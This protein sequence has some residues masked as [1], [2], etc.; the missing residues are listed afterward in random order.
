LKDY[1]KILK[2]SQGATDSEIKKSYRK[3][4]LEF[5]PDKN[6]SKEAEEFF[7]EISEAYTVLSD[8]TKRKEYDL[9]R[10]PGGRSGTFGFED[11]VNNFSKDFETQE[12]FGRGS[13]TRT[14][15]RS[16]KGAP[17]SRYLDIK[18][19]IDVDLVDA[20][21]GKPIEVSYS[22]SAISGE[23]IK[24]EEEKN[25]N[26]H[27]NLRKKYAN[28]FEENG[29]LLIK[30]RLEKLG[31]ED[32]YTRINMWGETENILLFGDYHLIVKIKLPEGIK[33]EGN[34]IVQELDVP[35]H[36]VILPS[37]KIRIKTIFN[38]TYDAEVNSPSRINDIKLNLKEQG[39]LSKEGEIGNYIIRFNII[40]PDLSNLTGDDLNVLEKLLS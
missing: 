39:I 2:V 24:S 38:K 3:L 40:P 30:I 37:N 16:S 23:L 8:P 29:E 35:L 18:K 32:I 1:Y 9:K 28:I 7:K 15:A 17:D 4:A 14:Y 13:K 6:P 27:L 5:H 34:N 21:D 11:W 19:S 10:S 12:N 31:N 36:K 25:L 33:L 20:I 22:R 26:I